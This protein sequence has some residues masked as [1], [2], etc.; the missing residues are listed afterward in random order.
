MILFA[1][2]GHL[3]TGR[4][5]VLTTII[6]VYA[7]TAPVSGYVGGS[8]YARQG[9]KTWIKQCLLTGGLLPAVVTLVVFNVNFI[10]I[11]YHAT[12]AIPLGTMVRV[13]EGWCGCS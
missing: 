1:I 8:L 6:F 10:A 9:G 4:G 12:R 13:C 5:S 11:Y 7:A 3:Y 2:M